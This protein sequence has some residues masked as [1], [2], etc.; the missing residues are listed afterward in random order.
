MR[1]RG[2]VTLAAIGAAV[3]LTLVVALHPAVQQRGQLVGR[4][5]RGE[6]P[7]RW[8]EVA[9][10]IAPASWRP[11]LRSVIA[12]TPAPWVRKLDFPIEP[13][14]PWKMHPIYLG[15]TACMDLLDCHFTVLHSGVKAH[16]LHQHANEELI[17]PLSGELEIIRTDA[18][19]AGE[20]T[21]E[22]MAPGQFAYHAA[23]QPHTI[24][25]VGAGP[26]TYLV[27]KWQANATAGGDPLLP[28]SNFRY[29]Q[30]HLSHRETSEGFETT[31]V[32]EAPT[33][34]LTKLH[35]HASTLQA[36][37]GYEAHGDPYDVAI[38]LL[39]GEV[40]TLGR[41]V[42]PGSVVFYQADE[43]HGMKN[44]GSTPAEYLVFEFHGHGDL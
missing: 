19:A 28:S 18:S 36:G 40:E 2:T 34:Y 3:G 14:P 10:R 11:T 37:A 30:A 31:L 42:A 6:R 23:E 24:R 13:S 9:V 22:R 25:G 35:C 12:P 16:T 44:A 39:R 41:R 20:Q 27:F 26:A 33:L 7:I 29:D 1:H 4:K 5:L 15:P 32:F 17:V 43:P 21:I 8:A 38:L